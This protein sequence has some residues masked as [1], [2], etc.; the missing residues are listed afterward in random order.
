MP[1]M[2][3]VPKNHSFINAAVIVSS[4]GYFVDVFDILL[5][6]ILRKPSLADIGLS[7]AEILNDGEY[8]LS[9]QM[10]GLV[11]GGLAFGVIGDR[12]GR[13]S[14][15]FVSIL[16]YS[17][18]N[19]LNGFVTN[20]EQYAVLRFI[21]GVG[22]AGELGAGITLVSELLPKAKRGIS[23][24]FIGC[25]GFM[26]AIFAFIVTEYFDWRTCYF[27]GGGMGLLLLV[28]RFNVKE[29]MV[30][31]RMS[32]KVVS[33]GN[34]FLFFKKRE[35]ALR[36]VKCVLIGIPSWFVVGIMVTFADEFARNFQIDGVRTGKAILYC[37]MGLIAGDLSAALLS[38][39]MRSRKKPILMYYIFTAIVTFLFF[40]LQGGR[41]TSVMYFFYSLMGFGIGYSIINI[42][43]AAEQFG[44]NLRASAAISVPNMI[45]GSVP[46]LLLLFSSMRT[47]VNDYLAGAWIT[48]L[49][50]LILGLWAVLTIPES[51]DN[52]L[53]FLET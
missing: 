36:Y 2:L 13:L 29:S 37:Y 39:A 6:S 10:I 47:I 40:Q 14:V 50:I 38:K 42:T 8:L 30:F 27:I 52:E 41:A 53:D 12:K 25:F 23:S 18:A 49:I 35:R 4:L 22:L 44:T 1:T 51:Y 34:F 17:V 28:C 26:G 32:T 15:L 9:I 11:V 19:I 7:G 16:T 45:R 46:V 21:S 5:F 33:K 3:Q 24:A 48:G 43:M 20:F 31:K